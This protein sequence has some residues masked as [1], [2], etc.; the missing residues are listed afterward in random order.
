MR[1]IGCAETSVRNCQ[2]NLRKIPKERRSHLH[3]GRSLNSHMPGSPDAWVAY[4]QAF[5]HFSSFPI[6][7]RIATTFFL[8][9]VGREFQHV[10]QHDMHTETPTSNS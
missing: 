6:Y 1:P 2:Y 5:V 8:T 4:A 9:S 10:S 3:G 7:S